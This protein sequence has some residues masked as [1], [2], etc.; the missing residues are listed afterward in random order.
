MNYRKMLWGGLFAGVGVATMCGAVRA[1][2]KHP[3]RMRFNWDDKDINLQSLCFDNNHTDEPFLWG[4]ATSAYQVEGQEGASCIPYNQWQACETKDIKIQGK[5]S[6]PVPHIS[7]SAC[8][9]FSRYKEDIQLMKQLGITA[10]RFSISW[11]KVEPRQG[12]FNESVLEHYEDV[13]KELVANGIKP[14]V[15]LHHY[16]HPCWFEDLRGFEKKRNIRHFVRFCKKVFTRLY[17]HVHLWFSFNT[18]TGYALAGFSQGTKPPFKHD[19]T[20]AIEVM[21]N[22]LEAH[23]R[24]YRALKRINKSSTIGIYKNIFQLDPWNLFN[25]LDRFYCYMG[26]YISNDA[27]YNYFT[28]GKF[29]VWIPTKVSM[30]HVN[31]RAIGA[32]D[33]I[34]LNYYSGAYVK[35]CKVIPRPECISTQNSRYTI[36]PEGFYR[37]LHTINEKLAKPLGI[38]I[39]VTENGIAAHNNKDRDIFYKRYLY[40][41]SKA[42]DDGIDVRGYLTWSLMDNYEWSYGYDVKYGICNVNFTKQ[43]R[44][45]KH[46]AEFLVSVFKHFSPHGSSIGDV[47]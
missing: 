41:L 9:H 46:G 19:L 18:F 7:G 6:V 39:Y 47:K 10:F 42:M 37:A 33:V 24:M 12:E 23:V 32:T 35:N 2:Y 34:G 3:S 13:C 44:T 8:E 31:R 40:A 25:P 15:T 36:Y 17:P 1:L 27:I 5:T 14:V 30:D 22:M 20:L 43:E 38:P 21:K 16:T 29:N 26:N 4:V 28:T 45:L 11:G